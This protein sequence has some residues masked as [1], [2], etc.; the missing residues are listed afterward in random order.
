MALDGSV[1]RRLSKPVLNQQHHKSIGYITRYACILM[2]TYGFLTEKRKALSP[3][4]VR[5][6][7]KNNEAFI[8]FG[9]L[10]QR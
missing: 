6:V 2:L 8:E 1:W 5:I 10:L 4:Y 7:G 3:F 9:F